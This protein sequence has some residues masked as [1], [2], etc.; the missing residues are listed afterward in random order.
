MTAIDISVIWIWEA[1]SKLVI[2][3][4]WCSAYRNRKAVQNAL[5][6]YISHHCWLHHAMHNAK[7]DPVFVSTENKC[8]WWT[9][10]LA[11]DKQWIQLSN[12]SG[13][14]LLKS[15]SQWWRHVD[16]RQDEFLKS[17]WIHA[18]DPIKIKIEQIKLKNNVVEKHCCQCLST[19][20]RTLLEHCSATWMLMLGFL[21]L[22]L[23]SGWFECCMYMGSYS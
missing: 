4:D 22:S 9:F 13:F 19:V 6:I 3:V 17:I 23:P 1:V 8:L 20:L 11:E 10:W 15:L 16:I 2:T 12:G 14:C 5:H 18:N 21:M 7:D